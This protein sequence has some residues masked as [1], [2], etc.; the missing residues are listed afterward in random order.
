MKEWHLENMKKTVVKFIMGLPDNASSYQKKQ[1]KKY[2]GNLANIHRSIQYDIRHG[3]T[4]EEVLAFLSKVR[5]DSEFSNVRKKQGIIELPQ[6]LK[7][8]LKKIFYLKLSEN[9][10]RRVIL[11]NILFD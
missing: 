8:F 11:Y 3:V 9:Y 7:Y 10:P 5:K 1:H 2:S 4:T 6:L